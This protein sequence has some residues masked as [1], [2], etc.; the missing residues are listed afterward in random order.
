MNQIGNNDLV[1]NHN[2]PMNQVVESTHSLDAADTWNMSC[3]WD[4]SFLYRF[5]FVLLKQG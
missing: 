4:V 1:A 3:N 5:C 2:P